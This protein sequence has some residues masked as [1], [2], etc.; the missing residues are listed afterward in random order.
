[1]RL[2][3]GVAAQ[4]LWRVNGK[5]AEIAYPNVDLL[6]ACC[7]IG[8]YDYVAMVARILDASVNCA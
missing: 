5:A 2:V 4:V 6:P 8:G 7:V 1:M 3:I